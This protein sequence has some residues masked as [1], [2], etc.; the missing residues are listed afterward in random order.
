M[1]AKVGFVG[2]GTM[3]LPMVMN[4]LSSGF[5]VWVTS[6]SLGPVEK[7]AQAGAR[8]E[9]DIERLAAKVDF[10][11]TCLP[12]P[13]TVRDV[14]LGPGKVADHAKAGQIWID[15]ST[16]GPALSQEIAKKA[17]QMGAFAL[18]APVSG[19]PTGAEEGT[20]TIMAGGDKDAFLRAT[21]VLKAMGEHIVHMGGPG[22][23]SAAKLVNQFLV[24]A[25]EM[26]FLEALIWAQKAGLPLAELYQVLKRSTGY[27]KM[28]DV[29]WP[30]LEKR[31]FFARFRASLL[32]KDLRLAEEHARSLD[33]I[34]SS[35][36][37]PLTLLEGLLAQDQGD[38]DM[39]AMLLELERQSRIKLFI[40]P[41]SS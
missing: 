7:A 38:L 33:V 30:R 1:K 10:L 34:L 32:E 4:L 25:H 20:L 36:K 27:S 22:M 15:H 11:L 39:A 17:R 2:L 6:R 8:H 31:D 35:I 9:P 28:M 12:L 24:G 16:V 18:D 23:G 19:G 37:T 13:E 21:P 3:G 41:T 40:P 26:A 29:L 14:Y 5:E